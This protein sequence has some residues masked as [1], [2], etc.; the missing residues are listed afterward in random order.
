MIIL[1]RKRWFYYSNMLLLVTAAIFLVISGLNLT[2][3]RMATIVP[4]L[5]DSAITV[6]KDADSIYF[7]ILGK[8]FQ[9]KLPGFW[10]GQ[11]DDAG[12]K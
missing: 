2:A 5:P 1:K 8:S 11:G 3:K 6:E 10:G 7:D 12:E 9:V 4:Q